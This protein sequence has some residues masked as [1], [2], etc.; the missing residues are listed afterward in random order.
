MA[1]AYFI[2]GTDTD[3]GKT[4]IA[5]GLLQAARQAG[6]STLGAKPVASGCEVTP[7]GLRNSDALA[8]MAQS[9]VQL[10]YERINP[11]AFEP[12][13]APHL[14][15]REAGVELSVQSLLG[16]MRAVLEQ[17]ADFTLIEGAGGWRVPLSHHANLS[18]LAVALR[19][20]VILVVGV[21]LGCINHALLSAEAIARD[22]LQLAGWVANIVDPRTSR[23]E[24]N[25]ASLAERLP[26]PC[27]G[28]VPKLKMV[29]AEA[30]AEHL[31][32]DLLD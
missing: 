28:R 24:E 21:R 1:A 12:A 8:L 6:L 2:A 30:V 5:A 20:P 26:A 11:Y 18:D 3:V 19:L 9:S 29:S 32:L 22:G 31:Q 4:T 15:A 25:L 17:G 13:I 7:K 16:P 14:A 23:L 10:P 27:L